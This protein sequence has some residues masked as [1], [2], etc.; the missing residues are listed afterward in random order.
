MYII[1]DFVYNKTKNFCYL[2]KNTKYDGK[3]KIKYFI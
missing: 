2:S 1:L 3:N